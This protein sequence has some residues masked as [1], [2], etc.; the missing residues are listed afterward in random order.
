V[1]PDATRNWW[2]TSGRNG[3]L[4]IASVDHDSLYRSARRVYLDSA[5]YKQKKAGVYLDILTT[6]ISVAERNAKS[7]KAKQEAAKLRD[8]R[9]TALKELDDIDQTLNL[10]LQRAD[11]ANKDAD[12]AAL[13]QTL[14]GAGA[15]VLNSAGY[16]GR[17]PDGKKDNVTVVDKNQTVKVP[18]DSVIHVIERR[19][20]V[21]GQVVRS[22]AEIWGYFERDG[23][24]VYLPLTR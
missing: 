22:N 8:E 15:S 6:M 3:A 4:S 7:I 23:K 18:S 9:D 20:E 10:E 12:K 2:V 11:A 21:E 24:T 17:T 13:V 19:V 16:S 1:D 5:L 14:A